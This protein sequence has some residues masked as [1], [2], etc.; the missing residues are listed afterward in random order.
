MRNVAPR[1]EQKFTFA[2]HE[3][4]QREFANLTGFA[5]KTFVRNA[6][7]VSAILQATG[8]AGLIAR[9][10]VNEPASREAFTNDYTHSVHRGVGPGCYAFAVSTR[11]SLVGAASGARATFHVDVDAGV[12]TFLAIAAK[13]NRRGEEYEAARTRFDG[14]RQSEDYYMKQ[15]YACVS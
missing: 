5:Y 9:A 7:L 4:A 14:K 15:A 1:G 10:R 6:E 2:F 3:D 8:E 13:G 12:V 11:E